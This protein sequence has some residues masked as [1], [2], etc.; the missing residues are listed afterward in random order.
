MVVTSHWKYYQEPLDW[1]LLK[2]V[3]NDV[4]VIRT[5]ALGLGYAKVIGNMAL[6]ALWWTRRELIH[7]AQCNELDF[8]H[9]IVPDHYSALLGRLIH[10]NHRIPYG[11]DYMDPWV[12]ASPSEKA[13]LSKAWFS[14][15]LSYYLEP[16]AIESARLITGVSS[17]TF[18][19][20]LRRNP[21]LEGKVV[22]AEIPMANPAS[23]FQ[24]L[25]ADFSPETRLFD[26]QDGRAHII[27][28][29]SIPPDF[30][31]SLECLL[32]ALK[33]CIDGEKFEQDVRIWLI[34]TGT[35][36]R[37]AGAGRVAKLIREFSLADYVTEHPSRIGYL[38]VL[39]H[40]RAATAVL[41]LGSS[42][43]H[44]TPSKMYQVIQSRQPVLALMPDGSRAAQLLCSSGNGI[45]VNFPDNKAAV[46]E[47]IERAL[48]SIVVGDRRL[49]KNR[50]AKAGHC[51]ARLGARRLADSLNRACDA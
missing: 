21:A 3:P 30:L 5:K 1:N 10:R 36:S 16:W 37:G 24:A 42:E 14:C 31:E 27:Y 47:R 13:F 23:D 44:Y 20:V 46:I 41:V 4:R 49:P 32:S 35:P 12:Y 51:A 11:I 17:G 15:V 50:T 29:G 26:P 2:L 43:K 25:T 6:R 28:A 18:E 48:E 9:I 22:T 40:L 7:L 38:D 34:G 8:I 39:W 45:V 33:E 19:G